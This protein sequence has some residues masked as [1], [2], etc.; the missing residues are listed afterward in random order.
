MLH[1]SSHGWMRW[2]MSCFNI[3]PSSAVTL[4]L[5]SSTVSKR[6]PSVIM[7][8]F[9]SWWRDGTFHVKCIHLNSVSKLSRFLKQ[10]SLIC[11]WILCSPF[12]ETST[13]C[14]LITT[15]QAALP[16]HCLLWILIKDIM[17]INQRK[18][19]LHCRRHQN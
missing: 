7:D 1:R 18:P 5:M 14:Q 3:F 12:A 9:W 13:L 8:S 19:F 4:V 17:V 16:L 15:Y 2:W 11:T 6:L 10:I